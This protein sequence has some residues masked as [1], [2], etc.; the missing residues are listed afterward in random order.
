MVI[1]KVGL[2]FKIA[3]DD[4]EYQ[5]TLKTMFAPRTVKRIENMLPISV[6]AIKDDNSI[7][8]PLDNLQSPPE[9]Q[10][11]K[12]ERGEISFN[13]SSNVL[14]VY[15]QDFTEGEKLTMLGNIIFDD[16]FEAKLSNSFRIELVA[17]D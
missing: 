7:Q 11:L 16:D 12:F 4:T 6:S 9:Y 1:G 14:K 3:G 5:V 8:L 17:N 13:S 2:G 15:L 10:K